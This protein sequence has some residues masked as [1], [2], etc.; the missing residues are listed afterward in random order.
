MADK[1]CNQPYMLVSHFDTNSHVIIAYVFVCLCIQLR[2]EFSL[3]RVYVISGSFR[4]FDRRPLERSRVVDGDRGVASS[5]QQIA[6]A[7]DGSSSSE[8]SNSGGAG[9]VVH[10]SEVGGAGSSGATWNASNRIEEPLWEW[11]QLNWP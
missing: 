3:C 2:H 7:M 1:K 8:T 6:P 4:S 5:A 9:G 11:E 10:I